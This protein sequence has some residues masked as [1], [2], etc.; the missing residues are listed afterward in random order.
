[1]TRFMQ[2]VMRGFGWKLGGI[3]AVALIAY[4]FR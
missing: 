4:L 1:L 3:A 2:I